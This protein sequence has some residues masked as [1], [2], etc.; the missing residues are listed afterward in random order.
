[1]CVYVC[2]CVCVH[3]CVCVWSPTSSNLPKV[4]A[5]NSTT[6]FCTCPGWMVLKAGW[7]VNMPATNLWVSVSTSLL[8]PGRRGGEEGNISGVV[9]PHWQKPLM[10]NASDSKS[11]TNTRHYLMQG[12]AF[13]CSAYDCMGSP[14]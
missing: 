11:S 14:M 13:V 5:V 7:M 9:G 12:S 6:T 4:S 2:V 3:V 10:P 1:M 8:Q